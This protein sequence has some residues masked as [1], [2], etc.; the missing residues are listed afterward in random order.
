MQI[1]LANPRGFCAGVDRAITIVERA[2]ELFGAPVYVRHEVVHNRYVVNRLKELG[3]IFI[4]DINEV[5]DNTILIFSAHGVSKA[6]REEA[7]QRKLRVFDATCPLVT[8]VHMEVARSSYRG[9]EVILIGHAGHIE[10]DG[11]MGQY[12]NPEGGIYLVESIDDVQKLQVKN[13]N[14]LCFT[15]QTTLSVDDTAEI[16]VALKKRFP[17]IRSPR[18][19]DI[20]YATTNRQQAVK[21]LSSRADIVLVVGSK[22]SSN[23]NRLAELARRNSKQAYLIDFASDIQKEWLVNAHTIGVTAGASAPDILVQQVIDHLKSL[24]CTSLIETDGILEN[25]TFEIPKELRIDVKSS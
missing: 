9:E 13:E 18:K 3:A 19:N 12:N 20:C 15:T 14:N 21:Q 5:P 2:L 22:N 25:I 10:V 8:K 7:K 23:S 6:V 4:E 16:I 11:T 1:I 24:G 17:D